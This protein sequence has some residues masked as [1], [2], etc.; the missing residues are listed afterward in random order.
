M[1]YILVRF[2]YQKVSGELF[3]LLIV[4]HLIVSSFNFTCVF[5][6]VLTTCAEIG[7]GRHW[8]MMIESETTQIYLGILLRSFCG[9]H[10]F[11][12]MVAHNLCLLS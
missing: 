12:G 11:V 8:C 7:L 6:K 9:I 5:G 4:T 2:V 3:G 10:F 1:K